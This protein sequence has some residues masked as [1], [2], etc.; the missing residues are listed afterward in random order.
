MNANNDRFTITLKI[1]GIEF[2]PKILRSEEEI[3]RRANE[4]INKAY[5]LY[6]KK[7]PKV[8]RDTILM[9]ITL[10]FAVNNIKNRYQLQDFISQ[11]D[12][13]NLV[14]EEFLKQE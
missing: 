3:Y 2:K 11:I 13:V 10:Q 1:A 12:E 6:R 7:Y 14:L 4:E 9:A 5:E 8:D